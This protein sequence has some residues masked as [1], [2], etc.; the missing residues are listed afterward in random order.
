MIFSAKVEYACLAVLELAAQ[1]ESGA[2]VQ[3]RK[4]TEKHDIPSQ[5]LVQI[6]QQLKAAGIV[7]ST[8]GATGGYT[9]CC[10]P[11]EITLWSVLLA[12]KGAEPNQPTSP[13]HSPYQRVIRDAWS[14]VADSQEQILRGMTMASL[15]EKARDD[16][17]D[18]YYI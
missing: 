10:P 15:L 6:L 3:L 7:Q 14:E 9:L 8:R 18:M 2:P 4:L 1:F 17:E 16:V 13:T 11:A 5:F 12:T